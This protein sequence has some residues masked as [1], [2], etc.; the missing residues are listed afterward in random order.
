LFGARSDHR[1][2][3]R[4]DG[5][6]LNEFLATTTVGGLFVCIGLAFLLIQER[7]R[8]T[9]GMSVTFVAAGLDAVTLPL[10]GD[11]LDPGGVSL[12]ER[13]QALCDAGIPLGLSIYISGL[14]ATTQSS[15][16]RGEIIVRLLMRTGLFVAG[17]VAAIGLTF[18]AER[19]NDLVYG[20]G[21]SGTLGRPGFWLFA[22]AYTFGMLVFAGAW[23]VL[24]RQQLDD[25][26]HARA[27]CNALSTPFL[28]VSIILPYSLATICFTFS[29]LLVIAGLYRYAIAQAERGVFLSRFLSPQVSEMVRLEGLASIMQPRE[30]DLTVVCCDLR[31]FTAYAEAVPSQAVID[32]LGEY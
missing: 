11:Q 9:L 28:V 7:T 4:M 5:R 6:L 12:L 15:T 8:A 21:D 16:T 18:P 3:D 1:H 25:G 2:G 27:V 30:I 14:L 23:A 22:S 31:G 10:V 17:L 13:S 32:L 20:L 26:E 24:A 29:M 19:A